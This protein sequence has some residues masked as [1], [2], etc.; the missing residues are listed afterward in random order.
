MMLV[1]NTFYSEDIV[2]FLTELL[3]LRLLSWVEFS[4]HNIDGRFLKIL[5]SLIHPNKDTNQ[6]CIVYRFLVCNAD[7]LSVTYF[8][9]LRALLED[10]H[11]PMWVSYGWFDSKFVA[12]GSIIYRRNYRGVITC[13][14]SAIPI[15]RRIKTWTLADILRTVFLKCTKVTKKHCDI[16]SAYIYLYLAF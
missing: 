3:S 1:F 15:S 7:E 13:F 11:R 4:Y 14:L 10:L 6:N 8:F 16:F 2:K 12:L 5:Y 9:D